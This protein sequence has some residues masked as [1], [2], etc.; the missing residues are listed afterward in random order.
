MR[1]LLLS[2][3][4]NAYQ[5]L[6]NNRA[7]SALTMLGVT[8]GVA[9]MTAI[10][11]LSG[12]ASRIISNQ[13]DS[14]GGNIVIVRP[15][16]LMKSV[17]NITQPQPSRD[18]A[19]SS[20]TELDIKAIE[21]TPHVKLVAPI[22]ILRGTIR[23]DSVAP[24]SSPILATTPE[25]AN[26]SNLKVHDGQFLDD[27]IDQNTAVVGK[28]LS[29]NIFGT[30]TSIGRTFTIKGQP[31]VVVGVLERINNPINY[32]SIDFDNLAIINFSAG[33]KMNQN[34]AQIQQLNIKADAYTN[35]NQAAKAIDKTLAKNHGGEKDY[36]VLTG[37]QI[38][39]PTSQLFYTITGVT[40]AI[41]TISL[42]IGGIGIMNIMLVTVAERTREIGIRK[43]LGASNNDIS[44]QF[45]IESLGI[46]ICGGIAGYIVG[47]IVAFSV[48]E[49]LTFSP[50]FN[51]QIALSALAISII[52]GT[53]F[54]LY[55]SL[56][57]AHKDPIESLNRH[58]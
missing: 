28:Q 5:S 45:L 39:Q 56:R 36:S 14:L 10:L 43:S 16:T 15:G 27:N 57:A 40:T 21:N 33:K 35:L 31:Y 13:I 48:G 9:S 12:G 23:A 51:W 32:N 38:S 2:H 34:V 58:N 3:I 4:Q 47:Y 29:I 22:M 24:L 18:Y 25:L 8:I 19:A 7:R 49:Y 54:G 55:P 50:V 46:S 1:F 6:R 37:D 17:D 42:V 11:A 44:W 52:M 20:I 26:I 30:E 53:L 41:A